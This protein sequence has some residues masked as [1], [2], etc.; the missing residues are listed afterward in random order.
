MAMMQKKSRSVGN[1]TWFSNALTE[2]KRRHPSKVPQMDA[3]TKKKLYMEAFGRGADCRARECTQAGW[4]GPKLKIG[5]LKGCNPLVWVPRSI[6][7]AVGFLTDFDFRM[8][9]DCYAGDAVWAM[10]NIQLDTPR[11]YVGMTMCSLHT[12]FCTMVVGNGIKT[13][14]ATAGHS[15]CN[16]E[17]TALIEA[18]C[19]EIFAQIQ[20][21]KGDDDDD[22]PKEAASDDEEDAVSDG[23][24][25]E[26]AASRK[27]QL[28]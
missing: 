22:F 19:P 27:T 12:K 23:D 17:S 18:V 20:E 24:D 28:L 11:P 13:A 6:D 8:I 10:A 15:F 3:D 2:L 4:E 21:D 1:S 5:S 9:V 7:L 16:S 14:M 26:E 25:E